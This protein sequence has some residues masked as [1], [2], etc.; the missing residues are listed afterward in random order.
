[1]TPA[2]AVVY[3]GPSCAD[4]FG[5]AYAAWKKLGRSN[6]TQIVD[7]IP[8]QYG[9]PEPDLSNYH[10]IYILD[11][12]FSREI[13]MK[14]IERSTVVCL[15]HHKT[16]KANLTEP[17]LFMANDS[18]IVFDMQK[19]G[20]VLA[21]NYFFPDQLV[22]LMIRYIQDRDLWEWQLPRSKEF[23]AALSVLPKT[24]EAWDAFF[25]KFDYKDQREMVF[26][27]GAAI[28]AYQNQVVSSIADKATLQWIAG[29]H[30]YCVNSGVL[31]SEIG[32]ELCQRYPNTAFAA[33]YYST[34]E[35]ERFSLRSTDKQLDVG[36]IAKSFGGGG[37]RNSAGFEVTKVRSPIVL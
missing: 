36:E 3:H 8:C 31:Q 30:V 9:D 23:S 16:A 34:P 37:H 27:E 25:R 22:P 6:D 2:I 24:F 19:S 1:M 4:G 13:M 15:D 5:A 10:W 18:K 29:H 12:S 32:H 21:W 14:L 20:A 26:H 35:Q 11:F 33:I 17:E 28:L 7:Y